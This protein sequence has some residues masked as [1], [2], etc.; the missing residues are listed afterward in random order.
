MSSL[1]SPVSFLIDLL[2][3][4][5]ACIIHK[6]VHFTG[7][8]RG[9]ILLKTKLKRVDKTIMNLKLSNSLMLL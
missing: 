6:V 8:V 1:A 7:M 2:R 9:I 4:E 3:K 5:E